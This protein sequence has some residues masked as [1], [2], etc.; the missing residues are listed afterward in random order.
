MLH[1]QLLLFVLIIFICIANMGAN[2][3]NSKNVF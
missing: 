3:E 1:H 2:F